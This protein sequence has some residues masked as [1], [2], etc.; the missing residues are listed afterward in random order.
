MAR[1]LLFADA[2]HEQHGVMF[3]TCVT[4]YLV[5]KLLLMRLQQPLVLKVVVPEYV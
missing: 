5:F 1:G 3:E 4:Y 2:K